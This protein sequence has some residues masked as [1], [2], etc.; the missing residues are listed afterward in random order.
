LLGILLASVG[1]NEQRKPKDMNV[2]KIKPGV[3][4]IVSFLGATH[5]RTAACRL[6]SRNSEVAGVRHNSSTQLSAHS[7]LELQY[8]G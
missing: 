1:K 3:E 6:R 7:F 4:D 2:E 8:S 5:A